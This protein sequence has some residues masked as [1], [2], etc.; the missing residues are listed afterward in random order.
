MSEVA[1]AAAAL[2][3]RALPVTGRDV[4]RSEPLRERLSAQGVAAA[5]FAV[6][7]EPTLETARAGVQRAREEACT[8]IIGLGGGC[9]LECRVEIPRRVRARAGRIRS[10][11]PRRRR[12][13]DPGGADGP[14]LRS[15]PRSLLGLDPGRRGWTSFQA[16]GHRLGYPTTSRCASD[17]LTFWLD[18][19]RLFLHKQQPQFHG[20]MRSRAQ[21]ARNGGSRAHP[22]CSSGKQRKEGGQ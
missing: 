17:R 3:R 19:R 13:R 10:C 15:S 22:D 7:G 20:A 11:W 8:L 9:V 18:T 1:P 21:L 5:T 2:G 6:A 14:V 12:T 16:G 4:E